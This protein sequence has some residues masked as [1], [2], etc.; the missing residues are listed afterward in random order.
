MRRS[1]L[2]EFE[3]LVL[4]AV[5]V[6]TPEAYSVVIAE[7]LEQQTGKTVSTGA[8]HAPSA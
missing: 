4:L 2:G 7:D 6:F 5:A 1:D 8:V 3:E